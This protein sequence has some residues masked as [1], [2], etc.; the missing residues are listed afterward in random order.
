VTSQTV[1][2]KQATIEQ[3]IPA[4]TAVAEKANR[5][6]ADNTNKII[7]VNIASLDALQLA[8]TYSPELPCVF[9]GLM[10]FKPRVEAAVAGRNPMLNLT[11]EFVKP[12]PAYKYP[13]DKVKVQD[14]RGPRCF[15]LP[16]PKTP[17]PGYVA[18]DGTENDVWWSGSGSTS[19]TSTT[20]ANKGRAISSIL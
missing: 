2:D 3:L 10:K 4:T 14:Q 7:G 8:A 6:V 9:E 11:M 19:S 15:G 18:L 13:T 5:F 20:S 12:Q 16:N 1:V 17:F